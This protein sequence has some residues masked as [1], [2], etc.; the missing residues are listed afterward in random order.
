MML[1]LIFA[2]L[3]C[4]VP[5]AAL[6]GEVPGFLL[7]K[8]YSTDVNHCSSLAD[9]DG[10]VLQLSKDGV[11]GLEFSCKFLDFKT[12]RDTNTGRISSVVATVSCSDD[13]GITRPDLFNLSPHE[14]DGLVI[15]DSHNEYI[16][17]QVDLMTAQK[18]NQEFPERNSYAWVTDTYELC[19]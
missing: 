13:S 19:K 1:R 3:L 6:A 2:A 17:G 9:T 10:D 18:L 4:A 5:V 16:L 11:Y 15:V 12:D 8:T 7:G 14:E